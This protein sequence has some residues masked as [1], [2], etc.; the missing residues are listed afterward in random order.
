MPWQIVECGF[1]R[2]HFGRPFL[3]HIF[4][5]HKNNSPVAFF[6]TLGNCQGQKS[7]D[8]FNTEIAQNFKIAG[9]HIGKIR[10]LMAYSPNA[11]IVN[12]PKQLNLAALTV[13]VISYRRLSPQICFAQIS[14]LISPFLK[15]QLNI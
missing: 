7:S 10:L 13:S 5:V 8:N 12:L 3:P 2:L 11:R 14:Q 6:A 4:Q 1:P 15:R 9:L